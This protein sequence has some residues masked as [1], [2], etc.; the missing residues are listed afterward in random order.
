MLFTMVVGQAAMQVYLESCD[1]C[2]FDGGGV[3]GS[4]A[5]GRMFAQRC[6]S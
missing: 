5:E 6:L 1:E 4:V 3:K 2:Y